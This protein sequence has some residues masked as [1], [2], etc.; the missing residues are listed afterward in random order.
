[1]SQYDYDFF[2]IGAGSGG[3]RASRIAASLGARVGICE[4]DRVGGTCVIRGCVPKKLMVY[5]AEF[6]E[7]FRDAHSYGWTVDHP[8]FDWATLIAN[9][10]KEIDRLNGIYKQILSTAGVELIEERGELIDAHT[11]RVGDRQITARYILIAVGGWPSLPEIPGKE[12]AIRS[13]EA[14][15]LPELPRRIAVYG[16]GYIAVEFA[17]IFHGLGAETTLVYR[18]DKLLRGFDD[19]VRESLTD[20]LDKRGIRLKLETRIAAL[21]KS[22]EGIRTRFDDGSTETYDQVMFATGRAPKVDGLGLDKVGVELAGNAVKVDEYSRTSVDNIFAVGD[23]TD[24][25]ALTPV[26]LAEGQAVAHTLFGEKPA[27]PDHEM[28]PS[29]VFSQPN[30]ATV[31]Y[32]EAQA[33]EQFGE[34]DVYM[35]SFRTLK[36]TLTPRTEKMMLKLIVESATQKVIGCHI[37]GEHAAEILQGTAI[38]IKMGATKQQFDQ[39]IGIHPTAAEELVTMRTKLR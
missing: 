18:G 35:S 33:K 24:R 11:V 9:K 22:D 34:I 25:I 20:A 38:A 4:E 12:L 15:H 30:V 5:A 8:T 36:Q 39:V 13:N 37:V 31:G 14:F 10:D 1:M 32:T 16:G 3:V 2:V 7:H 28:V 29:A 6:E 19:D 23:V 17:G 26:A 27:K 21:E